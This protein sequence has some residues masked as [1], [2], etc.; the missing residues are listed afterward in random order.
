MIIGM[1]NANKANER[2]MEMLPAAI[3]NMTSKTPINGIINTSMVPSST[4][5]EVV[6]SES[7]IL[8]KAKPLGAVPVALPNKA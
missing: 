8:I 1:G 4:A 2:G 3:P 7:T 6:N 5:V